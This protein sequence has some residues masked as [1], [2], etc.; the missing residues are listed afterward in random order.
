[1]DPATLIAVRLA[2]EGCGSP[3]AVLSWPTDLVLAQL[4]YH[5]FLTDYERTYVELRKN[6]K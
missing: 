3:E 2:K 6:Y 4:D 1:M 5:D